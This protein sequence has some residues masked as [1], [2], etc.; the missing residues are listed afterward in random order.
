MKKLSLFLFVFMFIFCLF[1]LTAKAEKSLLDNLS[2]GWTTGCFSD[3]CE[4]L[5][6]DPEEAQRLATAVIKDQQEAIN[7][8]NNALEHAN[9]PSCMNRASII[10]NAVTSLCSEVCKNELGHSDCDEFCRQKNR[11]AF[12]YQVSAANCFSYAIDANSGGKGS[13]AATYT[14]VLDTFL[15]LNGGCWFCPAFDVIFDAIN[16]IASTLYNNLRDLFITLI[17]IGAMAWLLWTVLQFMLTLHGPNVG[18]FMT[19]LFKTLGT[20]MF[21][22]II[23]NAPPSFITRYI[24]DPVAQLGAGL[25]IEIMNLQNKSATQEQITFTRYVCEG[26]IQN[27]QTMEICPPPTGKSTTG[28]ALSLDVYSSLNC[29]LRR[30]SLEMVFGIALGTAIMSESFTGGWCCG[31]PQIG[32][33]F[34]GIF[35]TLAYLT[36]YITV[37]FYLIDLLLRLGFSIVLLPLFIA[38]MSSKYT[39]KFAKKGWDMFL[40]CWI[41]LIALSLALTFVMTLMAAAFG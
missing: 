5:L 30:V 4:D 20:V 35:V 29:L 28:K 15:S 34:A 32:A 2:L 10:A 40:S 17:A 23:L 1:P 18:E 3:N 27:T 24:V 25:S 11:T 14:K 9:C 36:F 31:L 8:L 26:T 38:C 22:V 12:G 13:G 41:G 16:D 33:L 6:D 39:R 7:D 21:V 37:P 19:S